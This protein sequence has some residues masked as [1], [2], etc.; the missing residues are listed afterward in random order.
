MIDRQTLQQ[1]R[2]QIE[3]QPLVCSKMLMNFNEYKDLC[4]V[5]CEQC[6]GMRHPD[7]PHTQEQCD[8][9]RV[10]LVMEE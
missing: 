5:P 10:A 1:L 8:L 4:W 7:H 6:G 3:K 9:H 2:D